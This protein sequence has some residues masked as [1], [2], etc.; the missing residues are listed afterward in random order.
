MNV[1]ELKEV[2]KSGLVT[3]GAHTNNHPVLKNEDDA[4]SK[5]E[6]SE[7]INEL[8]DILNHEIKY[9]SYPNGIPDIDFSERER[10]YLRESNI[11]LAF[12]TVSDNFSSSDDN[13][14]IPRIGISNREKMLYFKT[15][16]FLSSNWE[17][18]T[19]LKP[20]GEYK[21]RKELI[22][23]LSSVSNT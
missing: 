10:A 6:I 18:I 14:C 15:K 12:T 2:D 3:I 22:Q 23:I 4:M 1:N 19:R 17:T 9:F 11:Q 21:E 7:S 5:Q 13:T 16:L 20:G 8:S